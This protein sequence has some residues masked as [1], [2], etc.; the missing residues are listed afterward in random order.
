MGTTW[1][2]NAQRFLET[3]VRRILHDDYEVDVEAD[4]P[5]KYYLDFKSDSRLMDLRD[6]LDKLERG[7]FGTC[8]SCGGPIELDVLRS[9]PG[10][11]FC[12]EC[13]ESMHFG[14]EQFRP[15]GESHCRMET[16][17]NTR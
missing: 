16:S 9:S 12:A 2:V 6:A 5:V 7:K 3:E 8:L 1:A 4:V 14:V 13:G 17:V 11:S 10:L 15:S